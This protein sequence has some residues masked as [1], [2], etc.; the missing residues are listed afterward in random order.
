MSLL[1]SFS[2][3]LS[4]KAVLKWLCGV[5]L[6]LEL[7]V[8]IYLISVIQEQPPADL[9]LFYYLHLNLM[10]IKNSSIFYKFSSVDCKA[11]AEEEYDEDY[12]KHLF[13]LKY[14]PTDEDLENELEDCEVTLFYV[15]YQNPSLFVAI[16]C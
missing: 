12:A 15:D 7:I 2:A 5:Y 3:T 9:P 10:S 6:V 11:I 1:S 16:F 14:D 8:F 4:I 13:D